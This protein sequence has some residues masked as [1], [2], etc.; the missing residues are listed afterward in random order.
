MLSESSA[1][2]NPHTVGQPGS[3]DEQVAGRL[4]EHLRTALREPLLAYA[5]RPARL[6]GGFETLVFRFRLEKAPRELAGPLILRVFRDFHEPQRPLVETAVHNAVAEMGYSAPRVLLTVTDSSVLGHPFLIM[7]RMPGRTLAAGFE[8]LG[9]A[10]SPGQLLRLLM[11]A[12]RMLDEV[13][14]TMAELQARLHRLPTEPLVRAIEAQGL[15]PDT[16]TFSA[17]LEWLRDK[18][19]RDDFAGL[20]PGFSWLLEHRPPEP[21]RPSICHGDFQPFNIMVDGDAVTGVIDWGR[22]TIADPAM[23]VGSTTAN[24]A[25]IAIEVP[26]LLRGI[27]Y[28]IIRAAGRRY[29]QA[30]ARLRSVDDAAAHYYQV[31]KCVGQLVWL[32]DGL[33]HGHSGLGAFQSPCGIK[34]LI[35]HVRSLTGLQLSFPIEPDSVA[36]V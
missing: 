3:S 22:V 2:A 33:L 34:R 29:Y 19:E 20:R 21:Q 31:F 30:Y 24:I 36:R 32:A 8:G 28:A 11:R 15:C 35:A 6:F 17:G 27:F 16:I 4:L 12:P 18:I 13:T 9:R 14:T 1:E 23:D 7:E 26:R 5:E 10:N 25:T